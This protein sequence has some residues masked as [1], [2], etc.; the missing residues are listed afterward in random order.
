MASQR[1]AHPFDAP[2]QA[3][4]THDSVEVQQAAV[5]LSLSAPPRLTFSLPPSLSS[6]LPSPLLLNPNVSSD[7][8]MEK[9]PRINLRPLRG[10]PEADFLLQWGNRKRPRCVKVR[11]AGG[12]TPLG[13]SEVL[14]RSTSRISRR[15][16]RSEKDLPSPPVLT[17]RRSDSAG[18]ESAKPRSAS[19]S[20]DKED[21]FYPTRGSLAAAGDEIC[22]GGGV[23]G[24]E[25]RVG[26]AAMVMPRFFISLSN[27]EKEEDFM[28][29]KGCKL[30][31]RPKKRSKILQKS[32][33]V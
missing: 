19:V 31:Q 30:P 21:R 27:K 3:R 32:L 7:L 13:R 14:R 15:I 2:A 6:A 20:P 29:M 11:P 12:G 18:S 1:V 8:E 22:G 26:S 5:G 16:V 9:E 4:L 25:E 23:G 33:L 24:G 10:A 17:L 28:A